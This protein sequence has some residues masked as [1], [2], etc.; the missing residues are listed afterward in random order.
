[1]GPRILGENLDQASQQKKYRSPYNAKES[2][3]RAQTTGN[4]PRNTSSI[5]MPVE[6]KLNKDEDHDTPQ[7]KEV[8]RSDHIEKNEKKK[9]RSRRQKLTNNAEES[10][11]PKTILRN[12]DTPRSK[13]RVVIKEEQNIEYEKN[14]ANKRNSLNRNTPAVTIHTPLRGNP[15]SPLKPYK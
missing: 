11:T 5:V 15:D 9:K 12:K 6:E 3:I 14:E 7:E 8:D 1:M 2:T 4:K 13:S 10:K